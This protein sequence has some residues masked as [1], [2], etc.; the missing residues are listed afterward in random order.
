MTNNPKSASKPGLLER[1][2]QGPVICAEG[3]LFE[4]ERRGYLQAGAFVPEVVIDHPEV[5]KRLHEDFVHAGSDIVEAFTYYGHRQKLR[6]IGRE[7]ILEPLNRGALKIANEVADEHGCLMAGNIC[8]TN[9]YE[10]NDAK[11]HAAVRAMY[12]EQVGWAVE[13][14]ADFII[15][16]TIDWFGEAEIAL[17]VIRQTK[18][19]A[20]VTLSV[21]R[22]E[23]T[24]DDVDVISACQRLADHGADVVGLNCQR[25]PD[26]LL[27]ILQ[28]VRKAISCHVAGLPVPYRTTA[29]EPTFQSL[30]DHSCGCIPGNRPF[31]TA[32]DPFTCNRYECGEFA[33]ACQESDIRYIGL[34]CGA[35]P[36]HIRAVAEALGRQVP[37]SRYSPDMSKHAFF[38][39]N[40]AIPT[41]YR[42][43]QKAI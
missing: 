23:K 21:H 39:T 25:G 37:G 10:R 30:T 38:G 5:V 19:P 12:E 26:T 29:D 41:S 4:L 32:L 27:P 36:H 42:D 40:S 7:D 24:F 14:G 9:V 18:L 33:K 22:E 2:A 1:L 43:R 15:A 3:Y 13:E 11:T 28:R 35:A 17:D 6:V 16:E 8:N 31:P 20:V 34:C